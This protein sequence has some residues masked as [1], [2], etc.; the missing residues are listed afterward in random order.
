VR[1]SQAF[2]TDTI[3]DFVIRRSDGTPSFFFSN[4]VDD[5]MMGITHVLR[6]EDHLANTPRQML[7][8]EALDLSAALPTAISP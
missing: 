7:I 4:A 5:A 2:D 1:G 6:G 8:I 3:G